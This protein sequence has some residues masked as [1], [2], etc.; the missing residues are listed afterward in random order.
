MTT[1]ASRLQAVK[2]RIAGAAKA[3]GRAPGEITLVAVSKTFPPQA[4]AEAYAVGQTAFGENFA[5]EGI[6]K[7]A[8]LSHL[9]LKRHVASP[10]GPLL[11]PLEWHAALPNEE[12]SK[13]D[14]DVRPSA[15]VASPE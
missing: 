2:A 10:E 8:A 7:I 13:A 15:R 6:E 1:I 4:I 3:A 5:Q 12:H 14:G 11:R 9:S